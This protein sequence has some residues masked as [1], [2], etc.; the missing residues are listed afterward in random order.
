MSRET[1]VARPPCDSQGRR[2]RG[3]LAWLFRQVDAARL[4]GG[5]IGILGV[6][7]G[8]RAALLRDA[9]GQCWRWNILLRA[10][11]IVVRLRT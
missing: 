10:Q 1:P 5:A 8:R 9:G 6:A 7:G 3:L 2:Q 4:G 11:G